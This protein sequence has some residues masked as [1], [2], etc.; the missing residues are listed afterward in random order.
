M[1]VSCLAYTSTLKFQVVCSSEMSADFQ[2]ATCHC[3]SEDRILWVC[4]LV[5]EGFWYNLLLIP[6]SILE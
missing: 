6:I 5:S 2:W 1:A 4:I 3:K